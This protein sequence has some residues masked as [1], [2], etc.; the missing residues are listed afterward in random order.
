MHPNDVLLYV[1]AG[2]FLAVCLLWALSRYREG[3]R[4]G[5]TLRVI[6]RVEQD[7]A[8]N[9]ADLIATAEQNKRF[10]RDLDRARNPAVAF[11]DEIEEQAKEEAARRLGTKL[12]RAK[13]D[14]HE[15][16]LAQA[17]APAP[18]PPKP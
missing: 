9:L 15:A 6:P 1:V 3:K 13:A 12:R 17:V 5:A 18:E 7:Q 2:L 8:V 4:R 10:K 16:V 11:L 14:Q